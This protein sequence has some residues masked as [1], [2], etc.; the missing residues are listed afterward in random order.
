MQGGFMVRAVLNGAPDQYAED[1]YLVQ[2]YAQVL[3]AVKAELQEFKPVRKVK[4]N[5]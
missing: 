1:T 5:A 2:S 3:K 4:E